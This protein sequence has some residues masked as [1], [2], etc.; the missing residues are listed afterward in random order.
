MNSIPKIILDNP[1]RMLGVFANS[2]QKEIV[3]NQGKANAFL[4]VCRAV[5]YPL[6]LKTLM[7]QVNRTVDSFSQASANL[8]IAK[9]RLKYAQFWFLKMTP[10][11]D[12]AFNH[13]YAGNLQQAIEIW[14]KKNCV[15]SLQN[16]VITNFI[17][18]NF[19]QAI[20]TAEDLYLDFSDEFLKV[21]DSTGT[22]ALTKD[23][24]I[25][26][27]IDTLCDEYEPKKI[28]DVVFSDDWKEYL[29]GKTVKPLIARINAAIKEVDDV[30][31]K[32][33]DANL[34]AGRKLWKDTN[35]DFTQ[36]KKMLPPDDMQ[37]ESI[38]DKLG[39]QILQCG[40]NYYNNSDDDDA[41]ETAMKIQTTAS[42]MVMG[43]MAKERCE[44]NLN[45]LKKIIVDL[46]PKNVRKEHKAIMAEI[47]K[48]ITKS[49]SI[50][51]ATKLLNNT[52]PYLQTIKTT[53]VSY[54]VDYLKI[55]TLVVSIA[56]RVIV[57]EVNDAQ[58]DAH[59][60]L[61]MCFDNFT[62]MMI[63]GKLKPTI[64]AAWDA[65]LLMDDFDIESDFKSH[66]NQNRN[67]LKSMCSNLGISTSRPQV[68]SSTTTS[69][70]T[71]IP[72]TR[73]AA[74]VSTPKPT[75]SSS[76]SSSSSSSSQNNSTKPVEDDDKID[77][78]IVLFIHIVY[79][80]MSFI[81]GFGE[82]HLNPILNFLLG[83]FAGG[84]F[85]IL[86]LNVIA[87]KIIKWIKKQMNS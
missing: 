44:D 17:A 65:T 39:L 33:A 12:V 76:T 2:S 21:A 55:S 28:Y 66:Y 16:K 29:G 73:T 1:F 58:E 11:D 75:T 67:A 40:I 25:Q 61:Q 83:M 45:V 72:R 24:L 27:F 6:D 48:F 54:N 87:Y 51:T 81:P 34:Q 30:D 46:P 79:G 47:E 74:A 80:F 18:L 22:L 86:P 57:G 7:P 14:D 84:A 13:L 36:L 42:K 77:W 3:A 59:D 60:K 35:D 53:I 64:K 31:E 50:A 41:A 5:E 63:I 32:D 38:A 71:T 68:Q 37:L 8:T 82:R 78:G 19:D 15:S 26:S 9:G 62:R 52:K 85:W 43:E 10:L 70:K 56:M 69:T 20:N 4:K 49:P 23:D